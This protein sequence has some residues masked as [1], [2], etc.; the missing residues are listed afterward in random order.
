MQILS[1]TS[2]YSY[3]EWL[4]SFYPPKLPAGKML[5]HY[6]TRLPAVEIN[7]T[8]YRL[9]KVS[10]LEAWAAQVPEGFRFAIKATRRI[11]HVRRLAG[12]EAE[13]SYLLE[14]AAGLRARLGAILFQLPPYQRRDLPRL[15]EFLKLL[16][17]AT[18]AA[19]E[20]RHASWFDDAVYAL[21][22]EHRCALCA[23]DTDEGDEPPLPATAPLAYLRLRRQHYD[24]ATLVRWIERLRAGDWERAYVFFKHED[25]AAGP[26]MA[27]RFLELAAA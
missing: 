4:G 12:V 7:N 21:L 27:A 16:P 3:R 23:S 9:P 15:G 14:T 22:A 11:T 25:E 1:G 2:G 24:D 20:F 6:A 10:L 8:F 13:T 26:R 18:P 19:F 17:P 5:E